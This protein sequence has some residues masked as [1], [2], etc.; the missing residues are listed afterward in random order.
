MMPWE[1]GEMSRKGFK[2]NP[3]QQRCR[4]SS[5][6]GVNDLQT[7]SWCCWFI[8]WCLTLEFRQFYHLSRWFRKCGKGAA[9]LGAH[10]LTNVCIFKSKGFVGWFWLMPTHQY[11]RGEAFS[12]E[13]FVLRGQK[14]LFLPSRACHFFLLTR[15]PLQ[16]HIPVLCCP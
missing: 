13:L 6:V 7:S 14:Y 4:I 8:V 10:L 16:L 12:T 9:A 11:G 3:R 15:S 2:N 5:E 1:K